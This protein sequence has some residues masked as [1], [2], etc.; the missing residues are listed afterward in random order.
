[1]PRSA[2]IMKKV[3]LN[4]SPWGT[5]ASRFAVSQGVTKSW[6]WGCPPETCFMHVPWREAGGKMSHRIGLL[7]QIFLENSKIGE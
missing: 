1:M 2:T 6:G 7:E 4:F 3:D 5:Q